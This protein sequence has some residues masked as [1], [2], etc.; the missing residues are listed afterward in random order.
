M[1]D[2]SK[3]PVETPLAWLRYAEGD[4]RVAEREIQAD[5]A[6]YHTVC[7]LCQGAAEKFLKAFLIGRGWGLEKTHD[8]ADLMGEC[9][10][11]G[12]D[13]G[14]LNR[15]GR[16]LNEYISAGRY[17]GDTRENIDKADA[18]E[19]IE[20]ARAIRDRVVALMAQKEEPKE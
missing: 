12:A 16:L 6:A 1:S 7:F 8:I 4:L 10:K 5:P 14:A 2:Q 11:Y 13:F 17:P 9:A 18:E 19:A 15:E 3:L 20:A